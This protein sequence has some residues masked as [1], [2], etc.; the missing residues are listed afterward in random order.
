[1][2]ERAKLAMVSAPKRWK[3]SAVRA[4]C[5]SCH[6]VESVVASRLMQSADQKG[7]L[8]QAREESGLLATVAQ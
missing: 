4:G 5:D 8:A 7:A 6:L 2:K 1:M 3:G